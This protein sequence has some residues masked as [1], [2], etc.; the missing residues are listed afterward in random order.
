MRYTLY[1]MYIFLFTRLNNSLIHQVPGTSNYLKMLS[2]SV[3]NATGPLM[4][5]LS[6]F[7]LFFVCGN[8]QLDDSFTRMIA[9]RHAI[10]GQEA[11][12]RCR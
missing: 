2:I 4:V 10:F 11:G 6:D 9:A 3:K 7:F 8:L 1:D 12:A 5:F